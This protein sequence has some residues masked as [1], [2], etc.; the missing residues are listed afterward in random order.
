MTTHSIESVRIR[1]SGAEKNRLVVRQA[2]GLLWTFATRRPKN[3]R[4]L[5]KATTSRWPKV[6]TQIDIS[7]SQADSSAF[8][9]GLVGQPFDGWLRPQFSSKPI[10]MGFFRA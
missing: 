5:P 1:E 6:S 10:S 2:A 3:N 9:A 8:P 4:P 7:V